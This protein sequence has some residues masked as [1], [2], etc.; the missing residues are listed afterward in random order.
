MPLRPDYPDACYEEA[1][2]SY[3]RALADDLGS[4][5]SAEMA[6][7]QDAADQRRGAG[8]PTYALDP[9]TVNV[10]YGASAGMARYS[11]R[12]KQEAAD[13]TTAE[14]V[15][16]IIKESTERLKAEIVE[17]LKAEL[18]AVKDELHTGRAEGH[19]ELDRVIQLVAAHMWLINCAVNKL[20]AGSSTG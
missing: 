4:S 2:A 3:D 15:C 20:G 10:Q 17:H 1:Q 6:R 8:L 18:T 9:Y 13:D 12:S 16:E 5:R 14:A 11:R 19:K 7:L